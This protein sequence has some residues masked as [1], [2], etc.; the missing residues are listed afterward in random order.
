MQT[1]AFELL[2]T[3]DPWVSYGYP[4]RSSSFKLN[5]TNLHSYKGSNLFTTAV[6][7]LLGDTQHALHDV[8]IKA[9]APFC[10]PFQDDDVV[11]FRARINVADGK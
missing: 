6:T 4:S 5:R 3:A 7:N 11:T 8:V 2:R 9:L 10:I 1:N